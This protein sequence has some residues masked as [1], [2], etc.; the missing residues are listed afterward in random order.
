MKK[1]FTSSDGVAAALVGVA[2]ALALA[3]CG[4]GPDETE[5]VRPVPADPRAEPLVT[6]ASVAPRPAPVV[7]KSPK[8]KPAPC[9]ARPLGSDRLAY[10]AIVRRP[11]IA[12]AVPGGRPLRRLELRNENGV[13]TVLG[14]RGIGRCA[15]RWYRVQLPMRPNG[16]VGWV[17]AADVTV[18]RVRTSI[19]VDLSARTV[20]MRRNGKPILKAVAAIGAPDTP[21]PAGR[22]YVNQR[23]VAP[24]P[25]G[26]FGPA[27]VGVS[28]FSPVLQYWAQGG[29]IAIHGT[30]QPH[31]LGQ[32][33][34]HGCVRIRNDL[35]V[36]LYELAEEGTPVVIRA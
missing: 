6:R 26:P 13:P 21:T 31:L 33:V 27:A 10:A 36:R 3:G 28:A 14:V 15:G 4:G 22:Y 1:R 12:Y 34:S 11:T 2:V 5:A 17:H 19:V 8:P 7:H 9:A 23:L 25:N 16:T 20:V 32:A 18:S 35:L 30:N 29:P 24:D